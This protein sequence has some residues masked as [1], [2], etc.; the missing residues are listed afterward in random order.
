MARLSNKYLYSK[1]LESHLRAFRHQ[2]NLEQANIEWQKI[3]NEIVRNSERMNLNAADIINKIEQAQQ[4]LINSTINK[5][6]PLSATNSPE[7]TQNKTPLSVKISPRISL[8]EL[9]EK[10]LKK[11][12]PNKPKE[13]QQSPLQKELEEK[14]KKMSPSSLAT[15][16]GI[17]VS[18]PNELSL[19]KGFFM[20]EK[21]K[22]I[23]NREKNNLPVPEEVRSKKITQSEFNRIISEIGGAGL[24]LKKKKR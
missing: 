8:N 23:R 10:K 20:S 9:K 18:P 13:K 2:S 5:M 3:Q 16:A 17:S 22:W 19:G 7:I 15:M 11:T 4:E 12:Y 14:I 21:N 24:Y 6:I 1:S